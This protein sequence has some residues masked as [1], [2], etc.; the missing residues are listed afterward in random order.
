M[1]DQCSQ[2]NNCPDISIIFL[3]NSLTVD[4]LTDIL[5][6]LNKY[7]NYKININFKQLF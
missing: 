4:N 6:L 5:N 7:S 2:L 3:L 1:L